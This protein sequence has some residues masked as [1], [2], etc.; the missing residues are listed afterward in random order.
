[1][2]LKSKL[3]S[4]KDF[5]TEWYAIGNEKMKAETFLL[6]S[7]P[8]IRREQ[9]RF[10]RKIWEWCYIY[11]ALKERDLLRPGKKGLGFGVGTEPLTAAFA[12]HGCSITA[13]DL[14]FARA[15]S[16]G[17]VDT[18]QHAVSLEDLNSE[19]ICTPSQFVQLVEFE[20]SDMNHI[21]PKYNNKYDFTWSSCSFEH[22]GSLD[23]GKQFIINQMKCLHPGG[24]AVHTTE[25]NLTS[26]EH[27]LDHDM[28]VLFRQQDIEWMVAELRSLGHKIDI[29]YTVGTGPVESC[30]DVP[31]FTHNP[32]LRLQLGQYVSTSIGL[33]IHK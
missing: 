24:V 25:F 19:G 1:M 29:D 26:N 13:T 30:V 17:W 23:Q 32:H 28:T 31:P 6:K 22:L 5:C 12:S 4:E 10:H 3:C 21:D 7:H 18:N 15:K 8:H 14:D 11:Q 16:M 20:Y 27:T 2:M 33:I 9:F